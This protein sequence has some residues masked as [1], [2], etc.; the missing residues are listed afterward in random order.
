MRMY[1]TTQYFGPISLS[2]DYTGNPGQPV[3]VVTMGKGEVVVNFVFWNE[4]LRKALSWTSNMRTKLVFIMI[5]DPWA[6]HIHNTYHVAGS[7]GNLRVMA[8]DPISLT[9]RRV[10]CSYLGALLHM[11]TTMVSVIKLSLESA[12]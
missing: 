9:T 12:G 1:Q 5:D 3:P 10:F 2:E 8:D 7:T 4:S 11:V 6:F